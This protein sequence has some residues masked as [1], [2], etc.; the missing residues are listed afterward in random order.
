MH[1]IYDADVLLLQAIT[2]AAKRRPAELM[3]VTT[4]ALMIQKLLPAETKLSEAFRRLAGNGLILAVGEG[5]TLS[6]AAEKI[7]A[8]L[9][10][11]GEAIEK[12]RRLKDALAEYEPADAGH[13]EIEVSAEQV[14]AAI[15]ASRAASPALAHDPLEDQK[16]PRNYKSKKPWRPGLR[17]TER[18]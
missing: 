17:K 16:A 9:P 7:M 12:I 2:L 13:P 14:S 6:P 8:G 10:K 1:P 11:K 15:K 4:A 18:E 3:E 5:F